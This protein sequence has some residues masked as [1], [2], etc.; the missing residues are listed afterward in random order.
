MA[1]CAKCGTE[2]DEHGVCPKCAAEADEKEPNEK[3]KKVVDQFESVRDRTDEFDADDI[4]DNRIFAALGYL[5]I[6]VLVPILCAPGSKFARFHA[7]QSLNLIIFHFIYIVVSVILCILC[8]QVGTALGIIVTG[9][10]LIVGICPMV[11]LFKGLSNAAQG[12]AKELPLIGTH[13]FLN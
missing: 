9:L 12:L 7:S 4:E 1:Y 6:F 3:V 2:L 5:G 10:C 11:L 8:F 13:E